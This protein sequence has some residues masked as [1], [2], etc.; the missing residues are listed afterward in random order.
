MAAMA[1]VMVRGSRSKPE[2]LPPPPPPPTP[3]AREAAALRAE[4]A[5]LRSELDS[6]QPEA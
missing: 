3:A 6:P 1:V 5:Q 2:G 4:I